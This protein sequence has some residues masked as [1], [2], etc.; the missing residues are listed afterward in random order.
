MIRAF[1]QSPLCEDIPYQVSVGHP[2]VFSAHWHG[3]IEIIYVLHGSVKTTVCGQHYSLSARNAV[4]V[5]SAEVHS[6]D[7]VS[8]DSQML[9]VEMGY[10][11]LG[12]SFRKFTEITITNRFFDFTS[13]PVD[14]ACARLENVLTGLTE[15]FSRC[16]DIPTGQKKFTGSGD[17]HLIESNF[18]T[19]ALLFN[20]AAE[21]LLCVPY[22]NA[23]ATRRRQV[24]AMLSMQHVSDYVSRHFSEPISVEKAAQMS[25]YGATRFC[26]LFS[27]A[28]GIS[29]HRYLI[30]CR[31]EAARQILRE[32][33]HSVASIA[34]KVGFSESKT[35]CRV[36]RSTCGMTPVEYRLQFNNLKDK[37]KG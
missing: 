7:A 11:F 9:V 20:C 2:A 17:I 22:E 15:E 24:D 25:C 3:E 21:L 10:Q 28:I 34:E 16:T 26:Q 30:G 36:F 19:G 8:A 29:F 23:P 32:S 18:R 33:D 4:I 12:C 37:K 6:V 14:A 5:G 35:F 13:L 31:I 1:Y 27:R